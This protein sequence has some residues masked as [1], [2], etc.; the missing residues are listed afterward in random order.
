MN[1][2]LQQLWILILAYIPRLCLALSVFV[3]LWLA[4]IALARVALRVAGTEADTDRRQAVELIAR[5]LKLTLV[6][7]GAVSAAGTLG[8]NVSAL[9]A[10]L[11]LTGF[12]LKDALSNL[13]SGALIMLYRP[14]RRHTR[15]Q[16]AGLDGR[17]IEI[18]LRYTTLDGDGRR[19]LIPNSPLFTNT[20]VVLGQES[21][22]P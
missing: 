19:I 10:G 13:L 8:V 9:V 4:G 12:A 20:I 16:V 21:G 15:I 5:A 1:E 7:I 11:G 2:S 14:F 22:T 18:D 3:G 17:A 6:V